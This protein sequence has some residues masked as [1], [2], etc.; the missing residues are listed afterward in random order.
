MYKRDEGGR[1]REGL[2]HEQAEARPFSEE[3]RMH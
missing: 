3:V 1:G 2:K